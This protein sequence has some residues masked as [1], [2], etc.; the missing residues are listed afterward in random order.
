[1]DEDIL[2]RMNDGEK[3]DRILEEFNASTL[4]GVRPMGGG[5][6]MAVMID[7]NDLGEQQEQI[8]RESI[9][10]VTMY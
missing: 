2:A 10:K 1:M 7:M 6:G 5:Q 8:I 9:P 4:D 3:R